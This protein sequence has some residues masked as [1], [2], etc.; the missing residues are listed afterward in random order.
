MS[1][2]DRIA[3]TMFAVLICLDQLVQTLLVAP[4]A[5]IGWAHVP[6]PDETISGLLGRRV[7]AGARWAL[8]PAAL[9]DALFLILTLGREREHCRRTSER[10]A[11]L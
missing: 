5:V 7:A 4:F 9:V 2:L 3:L 11:G 6:D 1:L 10:E 8:L